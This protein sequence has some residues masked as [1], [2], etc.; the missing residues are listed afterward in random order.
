M[1]HIPRKTW[2]SL[3][4]V[5]AVLVGFCAGVLTQ[6]AGIPGRVKRLIFKPKPSYPTITTIE[7]V[8]QKGPCTVWLRKFPY[9]FKSALSIASDIDC[10]S[11][12]EFDEIHRFLNTTEITNMGPGLGLD[13]ADSMWMY[14][15][16]DVYP[17]G[18]I[19]PSMSYWKGIKPGAIKNAA[20]IRE[21]VQN[22]WI[23]SLHTY[24]DFSR[25]ENVFRR[26][27]AEAALKELA[28]KE[29]LLDVWIDHGDQYNRQ[30]F[31]QYYRCPYQQGD[32]PNSPAYHTDLL[33]AYGVR[34]AWG[35]ERR[36]FGT[37]K[38]AV[39]LTLRDGQ[40]IWQFGRYTRD[41][42]GRAGYNWFPNNIHRQLTEENL[43]KLIENNLWEILANHFGAFTPRGGGVSR[44]CHHL[45]LQHAKLYGCLPMSFDVEISW[46]CVR[47]VS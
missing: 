11:P 7:E 8:E 47:H 35:P 46:S 31:A 34:Y 2:I 23:D 18:D 40:Q 33:I 15:I 44:H 28:S 3:I 42:A 37:E 36:E 27:L 5:F 30:N 45:D 4:L 9:P 41:D 39:P 38:L 10:C 13:I 22:G 43:K 20:R 17:H 21:Y 25:I 29:I 16:S 32:D 12:E 6:R 1:R 24:G 26:K 19:P 14:D